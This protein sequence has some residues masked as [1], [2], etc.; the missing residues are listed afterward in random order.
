VS[1][2]Q[3]LYEKNG[4]SAIITFNRPEARNAMTWEMYD[5]LVASCDRAEQDDAVRIVV[6]RGAAPGL[7]FT[8]RARQCKRD[9]SV[10]GCDTLP[11]PDF[12]TRRGRSYG[13]G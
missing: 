7:S 8:Y 6:L 10:Q 12:G 3:V 13:P 1:T 9:C 11:R 4:P 2:P 5:A